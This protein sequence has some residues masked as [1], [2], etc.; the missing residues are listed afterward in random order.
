MKEVLEHI[1]KQLVVNKDAVK[2]TQDEF[3]GKTRYTISVAPS[4]YGKVIGKS[5][6][7]ITSIRTLMSS[8]AIANNT[9]V[10]IHVT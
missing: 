8:I 5:G 2:I 9:Q 1:V 3:R 7:V 6:N 10:I 4:D